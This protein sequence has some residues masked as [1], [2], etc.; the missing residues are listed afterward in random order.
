MPFFINFLGES[1]FW[2]DLKDALGLT[3]M[4]GVSDRESFS[5]VLQLND[6]ILNSSH[7]DNISWSKREPVASAGFGIILPNNPIEDAGW[8]IVGVSRLGNLWLEFEQ[9]I[10]LFSLDGNPAH[11]REAFSNTSQ[12]ALVLKDGDRI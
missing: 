1:I 10:L 12:T 7:F 4:I 6:H 8:V 11:V 2:F 9:T 3:E 5:V